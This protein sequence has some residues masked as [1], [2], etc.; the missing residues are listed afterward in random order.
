MDKAANTYSISEKPCSGLQ[1]GR[2][3]ESWGTQKPT[4]AS[5]LVPNCAIVPFLNS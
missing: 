3:N 2:G 4:G 5:A 1:E